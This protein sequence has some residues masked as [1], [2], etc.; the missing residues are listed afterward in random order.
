MLH[1]LEVTDDGLK[2]LAGLSDLRY[3]TCGVTPFAD[4]GI[5]HLAPLNN[6][7][8]LWLD[9]NSHL[10]DGCLDTIG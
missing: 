4:A 5:A 1:P 9:F 6:L 8:E 10:G 7:E 3:F 2:S